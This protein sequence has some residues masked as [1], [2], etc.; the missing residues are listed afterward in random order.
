MLLLCLSSV[1]LCGAALRR[2]S[3][4]RHAQDAFAAV[5]YGWDPELF[6]RDDGV[7]PSPACCSGLDC[8][9][10][11]ARR[12]L[13]EESDDGG[14]ER[15]VSPS[16]APP[17]GANREQLFRL[18][19]ADS[20]APPATALHPVAPSPSVD[21]AASP[22]R[23]SSAAPRV[24]AVTYVRSPAYVALAEQLACSL[25]RSNPGLP[26]SIMLVAGELS[27]AHVARLRALPGATVLF[28]EAI[29]FPNSM[30]QR[31]AANW[32]KL[33]AFSLSQFDALVVLDADTAVVGSLEGLWHLPAAFAAVPDQSCWLSRFGPRLESIN[34]GVLF[35][36]PCP[37]VMEHMLALLGKRPKLRFT[38]AAAEQDFLNWYF[39]YT[40]HTLP[41]EYNVMATESLRGNLTRGGR[42]PIVVHYNKHKP[43]NG[44][45]DRP[46]HQFL[47][48]PT[49]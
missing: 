34:G 2:A 19:S 18:H 47:C 3:L 16:P 12:R 35:V 38:H 22:P 6:G 33:R 41:L 46:G 30:E 17:P 13:Q 23:A 31:Y 39:R 43:F 11:R 8:L 28:V 5:Y 20:A 4:T 7:W 37:A 26:L 29:S 40:A 36:R 48:E 25:R 32:L 49:S 45:E 14:W 42:A 27:E 1:V 44:R 24:G 15:V 21:S 10:E 9:S